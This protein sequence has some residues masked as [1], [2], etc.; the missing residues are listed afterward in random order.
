VIGKLN[1]LEKAT[2]SNILYIMHQCVRFVKKP[3]ENHAKAIRWLAR[4]LI[5][6]KDKGFILKPNDKYLEIYVDTNFS[7]NWDPE[8]P[9]MDR[10]IAHSRHRYII[11]YKGCP[12]LW[13]SQLQGKIC[14]SSS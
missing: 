14:L 3:C 8:N 7:G 13:K 6:T 11:L 12:L 1:Y 2:R 10:D 4:N 5:G 9:E